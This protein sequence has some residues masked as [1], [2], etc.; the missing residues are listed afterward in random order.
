MSDE[1]NREA[2]AEAAVGRA[3]LGGAPAAA[4]QVRRRVERIVAFRGYRIPAEEKKDLVQEVM[5]QLWSSV[6]RAGFDADRGFWGFVEVLAARRCIDWLRRRRPETALPAAAEAEAAGD[7]PLDEVLARERARLAA[8]ALD[9]LDEPCRELIRQHVG[10]DRSYS[11]LAGLLGASEGALR[12]RMF[13]CI[14]RARRILAEADEERGGGRRAAR[15]R[16]TT[17]WPQGGCRPPLR[18]AV[19]SM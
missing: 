12:I 1:T 5:T 3:F 15:G 4:S 7:G 18:S 8:A 11:E 17:R 19:I 9:R 6:R 13:R 16:A 2:E 10:Q 14:R